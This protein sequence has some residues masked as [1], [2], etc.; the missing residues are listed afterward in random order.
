MVPSDP[1]AAVP[2]GSPMTVREWGELD[3]D[4]EGEVV[5][6]VLVE[7]EMTDFLHESVVAF[8]IAALHA[9]ARPRGGFVG[10]SEAKF[11]VAAARGRKADLSVYLPGQARPR[12]RGVLDVAPGL[13][14]EVVSTRP[15]DARRDRVDKLHE[16]AAFGVRFYWIVDPQLR[17]LEIFELGAD[18]RYVC[19]ASC[20][21]GR[22]VEVPGCPELV[23]DLDALWAEVDELERSE[24]G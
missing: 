21:G 2:W 17:T 6:G 10:G 1:V 15:R 23:L 7:D 14:V 11:A 22:L 12:A 16:Y 19:A 4:V 24:G 13:L 18:S 9:W 8:L 5:D 3:E 20:S